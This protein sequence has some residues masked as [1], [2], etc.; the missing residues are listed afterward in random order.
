M[1]QQFH[2]IIESLE[3]RRSPMVCDHALGVVSHGQ[4]LVVFF[5]D[6]FLGCRLL[7]R[8]SLGILVLLS[9]LIVA[10]AV[11][12]FPSYAS[13]ASL[14]ER[15]LDAIIPRLEF[16]ISESPPGSF[17]DTSAKLVN[18]AETTSTREHPGALSWSQHFGVSWSLYKSSFADFIFIVAP[19]KWYRNSN[20]DCRCDLG[21]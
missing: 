5:L 1:Y 6:S 12:A 11:V 20:A 16:R 7:R 10:R 17:N 4:R 18:N 13:L 2:K 9:A 3:D 14:S 21:R 19:E 8:D 15:E